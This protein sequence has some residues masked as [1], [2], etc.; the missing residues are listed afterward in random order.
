MQG[1][2]LAAGEGCL[3]ATLQCTTIRVKHGGESSIAW[4]AQETAMR[5]MAAAA[6]VVDLLI[7][8]VVDL[9][10]AGVVDLLFAG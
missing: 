7:A 5:V 3:S 2:G 4:S 9:L 10:I 6:G 8:G 1:P